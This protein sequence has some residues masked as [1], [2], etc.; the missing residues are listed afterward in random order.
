[1]FLTSGQ[2]SLALNIAVIALVG[3]YLI[4]S[5]ALLVLPSRNPDL[6]ASA[7]TRLTRAWQLVAAWLSVVSM[8]ALIVLQFGSDLRALATSSFAERVAGH[9]LTSLELLGA[10]GAVGAALY[11]LARRQPDR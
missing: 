2:V 10:W 3:L 11:L 4:H 5:L 9:G 8:A 7:T 6:F 1:V